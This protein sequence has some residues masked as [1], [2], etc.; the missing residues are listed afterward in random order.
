MKKFYQE[1]CLLQQPYVR[2]PK[3][4]IEDLLGELASRVSEKV[5]IKRFARFEVGH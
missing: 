4:S 5:V 3:L 1:V 2:D